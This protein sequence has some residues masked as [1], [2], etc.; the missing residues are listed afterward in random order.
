MDMVIEALDSSTSA[1]GRADIFEKVRQS[2]P[3]YGDRVKID[4]VGA[5]LVKLASPEIRKIR[6][7]EHSQQGNLYEKL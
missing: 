3:E 5:T 6:C 2:H 7:V 4:S 1:F